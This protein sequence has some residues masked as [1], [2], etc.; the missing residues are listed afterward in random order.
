[1]AR[2]DITYWRCPHC[3]GT[4]EVIIGHRSIEPCSRCDG[5]GNALV[6]GEAMAHKREIERIR[7][8]AHDGGGV[9]TLI[10]TGGRSCRRFLARSSRWR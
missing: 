5:T 2:D 10:I 4:G 1:M 9:A 7:R 6:D 8:A 3:K